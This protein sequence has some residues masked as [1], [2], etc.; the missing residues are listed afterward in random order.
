MIKLAMLLSA[1]LVTAPACSSSDDDGATD[2]GAADDGAD[3]GSAD[4]GSDGSDDGPSAETPPEITQFFEDFHASRYSRAQARAASLDAA[5]EASPDDGPLSFD[6]ALAHTWHV[7]E[8]G[9]DPSQDP[10][11]LQAEAMSLLPLFQTAAENNPDD[12]RVGCFLGLQL[13]Q[14]G[15]F[16]GDDSL[17]K[18]GAAVLDQAIQAWPEF[19]LFCVGLA[20]DQCQSLK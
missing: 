15:R 19:N 1:L 4:D 17:V 8:W 10:A 5:A 6:R 12:D 7:V 14:A 20:Y 11:A 3:D 2:D 16:I 18:Q 13:V 9:R